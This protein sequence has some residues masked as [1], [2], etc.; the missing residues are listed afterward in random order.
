MV[1]TASGQRA[2]SAGSP[3]RDIARIAQPQPPDREVPVRIDDRGLRPLALPAQAEQLGLARQDRLIERGDRRPHPTCRGQGG[4]REG[5]DLA[6]LEGIDV[7]GGRPGGPV[8]VR[9]AEGE[10]PRARRSRRAPTRVRVPGPNA[11]ATSGAAGR[12]ATRPF[13]APNR[14]HAARATAIP[15]TRRRG[16]RAGGG[17]QG[18]RT[19]ASPVIAPTRRTRAPAPRRRRGPRGGGGRKGWAPGEPARGVDV[20]EARGREGGSPHPDVA[21][22]RVV[23]DALQL[24]LDRLLSSSAMPI[25]WIDAAASS[26]APGAGAGT[27]R[28]GSA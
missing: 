16:P 6:A 20:G 26:S 18:R 1:P 10:Q 9:R 7:H 23:L 8:A 11:V 22:D 2:T 3:A 13:T 19:G 5:G 4:D 15:R 25:G 21:E 14:T 17:T 27:S 28:G 12:P 24:L